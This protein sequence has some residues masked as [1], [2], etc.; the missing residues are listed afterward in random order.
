[1]KGDLFLSNPLQRG[2]VQHWDDMEAIWRYLFDKDLRF[3]TSRNGSRILWSERLGNP[4]SD[5]EKTVEIMFET[6][7]FSRCLARASAVLALYA[8]GRTTGLS[9]DVGHGVTTCIPIYAGYTMRNATRRL[10]FGGQDITKYLRD[11]LHMPQLDR[12]IARDIKARLLV[13][14]DGGDESAASVVHQLPDGQRITLPGA[15]ATRAT[16]MMF[17]DG[18]T[19]WLRRTIPHIIH[20]ALMHADIDVRSDL[21]SNIVVSGGTSMLLG[22]EVRLKKEVGNLSPLASRVRVI[23]PPERKCSVWI[24]GSIEASL[25]VNQVNF[26]RK[27]Q[28]QEEGGER[29]AMQM[30][31]VWSEEHGSVSYESGRDESAVHLCGAVLSAWMRMSSDSSEA[32]DIPSEIV[33]L[34]GAFFDDRLSPRTEFC[35]L[36]G[37]SVP[38]GAMRDHLEN[39]CPEQLVTCVLCREVVARGQLREHWKNDCVK[40]DPCEH[41]SRSLVVE[42]EV[43]PLM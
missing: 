35:A 11:A 16:E 9:V 23:A 39:V 22:F 2:A 40:Y 24:G 10:D 31:R 8:S 21:R 1:M 29:V 25:S 4:L 3:D 37:G 14:T 7:S 33:R 43:Y 41:T 12:H 19:R 36:C 42:S 13:A 6:F 26:V 27:E 5:R 20:E 15:E 30:M 18:P 38:F 32:L 28:Y 34:I 17:D